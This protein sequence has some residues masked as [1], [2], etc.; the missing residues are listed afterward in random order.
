MIWNF[1]TAD[2]APANPSPA[3]GATNVLLTSTLTWTAGPGA[4]S[5]EVYFGTATVPPKVATV[6]GTSYSPGTLVAGKK[7]FWKVVAKIGAAT[8]SSAVWS[9]TTGNPAPTGPSPANGA[10]AV[11]RTPVL[12]WKE[13]MGA[14]SYDVYFGTTATP[15]KVDTVTGLSYTPGTLTAGKKY[16]WKVVARTSGG[17]A[18]ASAVWSFKTQ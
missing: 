7:Y 1:K 15:P 17:A 3:K 13:A 4:T 12:K 18:T 9:F 11:S 14:A 5:Y 16:Y 10:T 2:S 6:T 8:A